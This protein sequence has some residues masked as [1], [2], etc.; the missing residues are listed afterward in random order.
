MLLNYICGIFEIVMKKCNPITRAKK[1][2]RL[3]ANTE[4]SLREQKR[5]HVIELHATLHS[6]PYDEMEGR[7]DVATLYIRASDKRSTRV[8][9]GIVM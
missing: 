8:W 3:V 7:W 6:L 2:G 4:G 1:M 5:S 9:E